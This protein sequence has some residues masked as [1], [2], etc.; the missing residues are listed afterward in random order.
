[1]T[2][3]PD[4]EVAIAHVWLSANSAISAIAPE[5]SAPPPAMIN[6]RFAVL[7]ILAAACT[8]SGSGAVRK[9]G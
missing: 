1:M 6:G 7:K 3:L 4:S 9:A 8:S 5:I 2:P